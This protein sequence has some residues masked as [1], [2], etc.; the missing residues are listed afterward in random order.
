MNGFF[1]EAQVRRA[2]QCWGSPWRVAEREDEVQ[3]VQRDLGGA[4]V[5][6]PVRL[7]HA[8]PTLMVRLSSAEMQRL[9]VGMKVKVGRDVLA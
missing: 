7:E 4:L 2:S 6:F 5:E 3:L 8:F 1:N 9:A